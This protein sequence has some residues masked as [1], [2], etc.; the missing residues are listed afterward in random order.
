MA[1]SM[2]LN[3]LVYHKISVLE[4]H[5]CCIFNAVTYNV[6]SPTDKRLWIVCFCYTSK[7][8][9]PVSIFFFFCSQL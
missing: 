4:E 5:G 2:V 6:I 7:A 3:S 9:Y 8:S 1:H